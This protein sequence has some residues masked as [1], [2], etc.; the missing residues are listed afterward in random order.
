MADKL[1]LYVDSSV[2]STAALVVAACC[3]FHVGELEVFVESSVQFASAQ[4]PRVPFLQTNDSGPIAEPKTIIRYL[5]K[6][7]PLAGLLGDSLEEATLTEEWL[8][9][10]ALHLASA[11]KPPPAHVLFRID[12]HLASSVFFVGTRLSAADCALYAALHSHV[13]SASV[14]DRDRVVNLVRWLDLIQHLPQMAPLH[15][16]APSP[17]LPL[18]D[19]APPPSA[20]YSFNF[21]ALADA[22]ATKERPKKP[23]AAAPAGAAGAGEVKEA[24]KKSDAKSAPASGDA[25]KE[26]GKKEGGKK[27]AKPE[28][29]KKEEKKSDV[30][31][32]DAKKGESKAAAA[33]AAGNVKKSHSNRMDV[34]VGRIVS[35]KPHPTDATKYAEMIDLGELGI[36]SVVSGVA[37]SIPISEFATDRLVTV[38]ANVGSV[39][40]GGVPSEGIVLVA[41]SADGKTKE[42]VTPPAGAKVGERITFPGGPGGPPDAQV[43]SKNIHEIKKALKTNANRLAVYGDIPFTTSAGP[44]AVESVAGG[45]VA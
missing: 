22:V 4:P 34:R 10:Y 35:A 44:C 3:D 26:G 9:V 15:N 25:K 30:K 12:Q 17:P 42:L 41:T 18:L 7:K 32:V 43:A 39:E 11:A 13:A 38:W 16:I 2:H 23:T 24:D 45:T 1:S 8:T 19:L 36:R 29:G 28:A 6:R 14:E 21:A 27:E 31:P 37:N 33:P 5:A 20:I 40:M